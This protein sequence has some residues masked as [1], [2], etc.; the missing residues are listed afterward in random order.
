MPTCCRDN[1]AKLFYLRLFLVCATALVFLSGLL[2]SFINSAEF[3]FT[4]AGSFVIHIA[5][6]PARREIAMTIVLGFLLRLA[7]GATIGVNPY[8]GSALISSAGFLGIS[9]LIVLA[10]TSNQNKRLSVFKTAAFFP[11]V[12]CIVGCILPISNSLSPVTFDAHLLAVDGTLGYLPSFVLGRIISG[13]PLLWDFVT[14][15]YYALPLPVALLCAYALRNEQFSEVRRLLCLFG[16]MCVVGFFIYAVCPATG[17]A[18]AF[19]EYFPLKPPPLPDILPALLSVPNAPRN[20]MPSLHLSAA[21]L[22]FLNT[23]G[24]RKFSRIAAGLFLG[25]TAFAILA[26]GEHYLID[27]IV[28][29]PFA[30]MFQAAFAN[31]SHGNSTWRYCAMVGSAGFVAG[32]LILLRFWIQP[33]VMWPYVTY[34]IAILTI[35]FSVL[36]QHK[37]SR[38]DHNS[39]LLQTSWIKP[40]VIRNN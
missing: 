4:L 22:V 9:S 13:H 29:V 18:Y 2:D 3:A 34:F 28:A 30:L 10:Y 6:R 5:A 14:T 12:S 33:L 31:P 7:Y 32:W 17:P 16:V 8:F 40:E 25:G 11:F 21:L 1:E 39:Q 26:L 20:A 19:R 15:V 23:S 24:M 38:Q 27:I 36:A 37:M 35:G